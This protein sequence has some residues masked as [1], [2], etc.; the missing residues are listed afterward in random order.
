[1]SA[2]HVDGRIIDVHYYYYIH[3]YKPFSATRDGPRRQFSVNRNNGGCQKEAGWLVVTGT[4]EPCQPVRGH[5][6]PPPLPPSTSHTH[7]HQLLQS[8]TYQRWISDGECMVSGRG[9][10]LVPHVCLCLSLPLSVSHSPT[11]PQTPVSRPLCVSHSP[12]SVSHSP[13]SPNTCQSPSVC[14]SQPLPSPN[15]FMSPSLCVSQPPS[16][17]TSQSLCVSHS[18]SSPNISQSPSLSVS[19]T[20]TN[21]CL[22]IT[23]R[24]IWTDLFESLV[25]L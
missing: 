14:V 6:P 3:F 12:L 2:Q 19:N 11:L 8:N 25:C 15:I 23:F 20:C 4:L 9:T 16:P 18:P 10:H 1:M 24:Q 22:R 5:D 7:C 21:I 17:N 13:P